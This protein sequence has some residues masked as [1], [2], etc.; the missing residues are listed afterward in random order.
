MFVCEWLSLRVLVI[1]FTVA[2]LRYG[3]LLE[4]GHG[5]DPEEVALQDR[6]LQVLALAWLAVYLVGVY[7]G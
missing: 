4:T 7:V 3:L 2:I 1:P 5:G 6:P